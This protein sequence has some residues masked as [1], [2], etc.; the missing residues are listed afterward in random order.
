MRVVR[1]IKLTQSVQS[2]RQYRNAR[3]TAGRHGDTS[4]ARLIR[5]PARLAPDASLRQIDSHVTW[6]NSRA[7]QIQ[8]DNT[9]ARLVSDVHPEWTIAA[10]KE[11][12]SRRAVNT[13]VIWKTRSE[14]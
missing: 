2:E 13:D 4:P 8:M 9:N 10:P 5:N 6:Q 7:I 3:R 14:S 12:R 11:A 1:F